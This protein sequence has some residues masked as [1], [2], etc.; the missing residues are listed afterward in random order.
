MSLPVLVS[1]L[2]RSALGDALSSSGFAVKVV[3]G[4][5]SFDVRVP[6]NGAFEACAFILLTDSSKQIDVARVR[7][8][9]YAAPHAFLLQPLEGRASAAPPSTAPPR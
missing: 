3:A 5:P 1:A 9:A 6:A 8:L 2:G 7:A 4:A